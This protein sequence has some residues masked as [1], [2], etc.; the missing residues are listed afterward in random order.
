MPEPTTSVQIL[1]E[2]TLEA[3]RIAAAAGDATIVRL[4]GG[5]AIRL[6][7][8]SVP[9][10]LRR[11]FED[12]DYVVPGRGGPQ[13]ARLLATLGYE[14]NERFN[15][16]NGRRRMVFYDHAHHRHVDVFVGE[17]RMCHQVDLERRLLVDSPTIPLA[18]LLLTKLQVVDVNPKDLGDIALLLLG[19]EIADHDD[20][21]VNAGHV[22]EVLGADW[23]LWRTATGTLDELGRRL[24]AMELP[25]GERTIIAARARALRERID[26]HP[27][28]LRW[29]SRAKVGERKRWYEQPEEIGHAEH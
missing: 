10:A 26:E 5:V 13:A 1:E 24:A 27:K 16:I 8:P 29:R 7:A 23:G 14:P 17:F 19:H 6:H 22:A 20:E 15:A 21:A 9:D 2:P 18:D 4:L 25:A 28:S 12:L 3:R 11:G